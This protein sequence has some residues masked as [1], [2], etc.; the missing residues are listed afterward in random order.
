MERLTFFELLVI[1]GAHTLL[2]FQEPYRT[3]PGGC[4]WNPDL[5]VQ[6]I[7]FLAASPRSECSENPFGGSKRETSGGG[8]TGPVAVDHPLCHV[9]L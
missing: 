8:G 9:V 6:A 2:G 5:R 4:S 3:F 7:G 1:A